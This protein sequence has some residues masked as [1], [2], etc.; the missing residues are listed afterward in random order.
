MKL[1]EHFDTFLNEILDKKGSDLHFIAGDPARIRLYGDL[2]SLRPDRLEASF[3]KDAL[4]EIM[5]KPAVD[6]FESKEGADFAYNLQAS[7][8]L[9]RSDC[10]SIPS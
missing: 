9:L 4:Y 8:S 7:G 1:K 6:R 3:V 5:P 2:Q 10:E